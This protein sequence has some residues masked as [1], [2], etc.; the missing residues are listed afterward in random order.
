VAYVKGRLATYGGSGY[1]IDL[2][3]ASTVQT[4]QQQ[5]LEWSS[6]IKRLNASD[7]IGLFILSH[8]LQ[9]HIV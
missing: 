1:A 9:P 4:I 3:S 8:H 5:A 6:E 2:P 7:W